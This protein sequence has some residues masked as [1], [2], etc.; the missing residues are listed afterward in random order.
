MEY[1]K[2]KLTNRKE[3]GLKILKS[4]ARLYVEIST[5]RVIWT[6]SIW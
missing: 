5:G 1:L 3:F 6:V 4:K 2:C